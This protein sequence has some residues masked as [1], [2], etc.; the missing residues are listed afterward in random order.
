MI[1][2]PDAA[3]PL[4]AIAPVRQEKEA[5]P[6]RKVRVASTSRAP[7]APGCA[8]VVVAW[9]I[10]QSFISFSVF[11]P[12]R[13]PAHQRPQG[14]SPDDKIRRVFLNICFSVRDPRHREMIKLG[15]SG[16]PP[17][18]RQQSATI[19]K[20]TKRCP[21]AMRKALAALTLELALASSLY[22]QQ[23]CKNPGP[24]PTIC[25][26][27]T[28]SAPGEQ[29]RISYSN[30]VPVTGVTWTQISIERQQADGNWNT[31]GSGLVPYWPNEQVELL[32]ER[33]AHDAGYDLKAVSSRRKGAEGIRPAPRP[34]IFCTKDGQMFV[35]DHYGRREE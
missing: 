3:Q 23:L 29:F 25:A 2:S 1:V 33:H 31:I 24:T 13:N 27:V 14:T 19:L 26:Q 4:R 7:S 21:A 9:E 35:R 5:I 22:A 28:G 8:S 32:F 12:Y 18:I 20:S 30:P 11:A 17:A 34:L 15:K 16:N 6:D 10:S